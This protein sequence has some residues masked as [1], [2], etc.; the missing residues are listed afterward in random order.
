VVRSIGA[1]F[2]AAS[3][4][5]SNAWFTNPLFWFG[6]VGPAILLTIAFLYFLWLGHKAKKPSQRESKKGNR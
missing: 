3:L 6:I 2:A 4:P 1:N 5:N